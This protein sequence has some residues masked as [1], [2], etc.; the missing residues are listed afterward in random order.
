MAHMKRIICTL[1][2]FVLIGMG[3]EVASA[4][5]VTEYIDDTFRKSNGYFI[6]YGVT[7]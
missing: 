2:A 1:L 6:S 3:T 4:S 7:L 5:I